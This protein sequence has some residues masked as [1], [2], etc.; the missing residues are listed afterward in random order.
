MSIRQELGISFLL[1]KF[2]Y[3]FK[4]IDKH[5]NCRDYV[6]LQQVFYY[7]L[8]TAHQYK[9]DRIFNF[10]SQFDWALD[11]AKH[12]NDKDLFE[13]LLQTIS[14]ATLINLSFGALLKDKKSHPFD[15]IAL[16]YLCDKKT[17]LAPQLMA[18]ATQ[19]KNDEGLLLSLYNNDKL[20]SYANQNNI[21]I[22]KLINAIVSKNNLFYITALK[23]I[24]DNIKAKTLL[25]SD[26]NIYTLYLYCADYNLHDLKS[27][28]LENEHM[29]IQL[30]KNNQFNKP[31]FDKLI[32]SESLLD[33]IKNNEVKSAFYTYLDSNPPVLSNELL[34]QV[35]QLIL[36]PYTRESVPSAFSETVVRYTI[37][38]SKK[39]PKDNTLK[40][41][42]FDIV[43]YSY[44]NNLNIITLKLLMY[45][46]VAHNKLDELFCLEKHENFIKAFDQDLYVETFQLA[47]KLEASKHIESLAIHPFYY[48]LSFEYNFKL[49]CYFIKKNK[50][51]NLFQ[52]LF[53]ERFYGFLTPTHYQIISKLL[54]AHKPSGELQDKHDISSFAQALF[55]SYC[56]HSQKVNKFI[57]FRALIQDQQ[58]YSFQIIGKYLALLIKK[59]GLIQ[60]MQHYPTVH[61]QSIIGLHVELNKEIVEDI[62]RTNV[63]LLGDM[64]SAQN[65]KLIHKAN[66]LFLKVADAF[67]DKF[68]IYGNTDDNRILAIEKEIKTAL[69]EQIRLQA[70]EQ[71]KNK[72]DIERQKTIINYIKQNKEELITENQ[73][74]M[75][76]FRAILTNIPNLM[77][78]THFQTAWLSYD[79]GYVKEVLFEGNWDNYRKFFVTPPDIFANGGTY[80]AGEIPMFTNKLASQEIRKRACYY[81]LLAN[82]ST[83]P[84]MPK[85]SNAEELLLAEAHKA[86]TIKFRIGNFFGIISSIYRTNGFGISTCYPGHLTS[87]MNMGLQHAIGTPISK[88]E[89][90]DLLIV[91]VVRQ[92]IKDFICLHVLWNENDKAEKV[93]DLLAFK[94][95]DAK[96]LIAKT[97]SETNKYQLYYECIYNNIQKL[98]EMVWQDLPQDLVKEENQQKLR[99][100][101]ENAI[102]GFSGNEY[103]QTCIFEDILESPCVLEDINAEN[104]NIYLTT[105]I[106]HAYFNE[107]YDCI[108]SEVLNLTSIM[109]T[110]Q[111]KKYVINT[112]LCKI[113]LAITSPDLSNRD[114]DIKEAIYELGNLPFSVP[115]DQVKQLIEDKKSLHIPTQKDPVL[116]AYQSN[117]E[118]ETKKNND[119]KEGQEAEPEIKRNNKNKTVLS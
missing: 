5:Y 48:N 85:T 81:W 38:A 36:H 4:L 99:A 91:P 57:D 63:K 69:L 61:I 100:I 106:K 22:T 71:K 52:Q 80:T 68:N 90:I 51:L 45:Y 64:E 50:G 66:D 32:S 113:I 21:F 72:L 15:D 17:N 83:D 43:Q 59:T 114:S 33:Y 6:M 73:E 95:D 87:I 34:P 77:D 109:P 75:T 104:D 14:D 29:F 105:S 97:I 16:E 12:N 1:E 30:L 82:D 86:D 119:Q 25:L 41:F 76:E 47:L 108:F 92:R 58:I 62:E 70:K 112:I 78:I 46:C 118:A 31:F 39:A 9:F 107:L 11:V 110:I 2:L 35:H 28:I 98:T 116:F 101:I 84:V 93:S 55:S 18:L 40:S 23:K 27:K 13:A 53:D 111:Q 37:Q 19:S 88:I 65:K 3:I 24:L 26:E 74:R 117:P 60:L 10:L 49:L 54:L 20:Q 56:V 96:I 102:L 103:I 44:V 7:C 8:K 79:K 67:K 115:L 42:I 94:I 89:I